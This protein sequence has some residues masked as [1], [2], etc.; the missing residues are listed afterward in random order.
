MSDKQT[1]KQLV[2]SDKCVQS[3]TKYNIVNHWINI[4]LVNNTE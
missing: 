2:I 3:Q 1:Q 4:L